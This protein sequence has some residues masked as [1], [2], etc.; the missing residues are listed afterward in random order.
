MNAV[1]LQ[2]DPARADDFDPV[3]KVVRK[4]QDI[5]ITTHV[6]ADPDALG[7]EL[8]LAEALRLLGKNP[9][10]INPTPI[11]KNYAFLNSNNEI[12]QYDPAVGLKDQPFDCVFIL[13]IS[14]WERLGD[15]ATVLQASSKPKICMDHHPYIASY[16]DHRLVFQS[17]CATAEI[18]YDLIRL[19]G[20]TVNRRI[21]ECLYSA[22]L[23]DTGAFSFSNTSVRSHQL[24]A[25]FLSTG[26]DS[27]KI[28][29]QL[30]QNYSANRLRF[31]GQVLAS[32]Q[33]DCEE[34]L[35]WMT[36]TYQQLQENRIDPDDLE[37]I[38]DTPRNCKNVLLS[39][40]F[41]EVKP[42]DVK[43][44]LR[45]KGDFNA[46][47][48]AT[49]FSGG[50]HAHASGIRMLCPLAE[51]ERRVLDS[52]RDDLKPFLRKGTQEPA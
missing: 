26:I 18:V 21:A 46:N 6:N 19:L 13:D 8:A 7:S 30:Y 43:I 1:P 15:L 25:E 10:I 2:K 20:V 16:E 28:Y 23:T 29:E 47:R 11:Y 48:L 12:N 36:V 33:F 14:R 41:L 34:K 42:G 31:S 37:G 4:A 24:A 39:I 45:A 27:R 49:R 3:L 51:A 44:S 22:I 9:V 17:A 32:L 35:A 50:G 5:L 40:L 38:A 52:A